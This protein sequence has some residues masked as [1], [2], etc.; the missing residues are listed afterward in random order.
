MRLFFAMLVA[1]LIGSIPTG[2]LFGKMVKK[3][4]IRKQGS[5]NVGATNVF[6]VIGKIPALITLIVDMAKGAFVVSVG[7]R[8]L[9]HHAMP[10]EFYPFVLVLGI[11]VLAGHNWPVFLD[12]KGGKGVATGAGIIFILSPELLF[13]GISCWIILFA[14]TRVVSFSSVVATIAVAAASYYFQYP[15]ELRV[16]LIIVWAIIFFKHRSNIERLIRKQEH[17]FRGYNT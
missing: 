4:D 9:Y 7:A 8:S 3:T 12:F 11:C 1:Y 17:G 10:L 16:F 2:Y 15:G 13:I 6:R 14:L 5:G